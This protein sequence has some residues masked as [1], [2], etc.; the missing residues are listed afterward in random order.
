MNKIKKHIIPAILLIFIPFFFSCTNNN[1]SNVQSRLKNKQIVWSI[2]D[3]PHFLDPGLCGYMDGTDVINNMFEGLFRVTKKDNI[4]FGVVKSYSCSEDKK[5][6][7]F[8]FKDDVYWSDGKKVSPKDFEFSW[9]RVL[10]PDFQSPRKNLFLSLKNADNI[11]N[12]S[13]DISSLGVKALNDHQ[14]KIDLEHPVDHLF[15]LLSLTPFMPIR[16][17][18]VDSE[19]LFIKDTKT[20]ISN[21]P[22]FLERVSDNYLILKKNIFY[23]NA[24][25][26]NVGS[27]LV[28]FINDS[29]TAYIGYKSKNIDIIDNVPLN[30]LQ[31]LYK[32]DEFISIPYYGMYFYSFNLNLNCLKNKKTRQAISAAIDRD[33]IIKKIRKSSEKPANEYIHPDFMKNITGSSVIKNS[34][35]LKKAKKLFLESGFDNNNKFPELEILFNS[36]SENKIIAEVVQEMLKNN[37]NIDVKLH[38]NEWSIFNNKRKKLEY[39]G[40]VKN[41]YIVESFD[42]ISFLE[43][44]RPGGISYCG[45]NNEKYNLILNNILNINSADDKNKEILKAAQILDDEMPIIPLFYYSSSSLAQPYIKNY[46]INYIGYKFLGF[47]KI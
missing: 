47:I 41:S 46:Y 8:E 23:N 19:N 26:S 18:M 28:K 10:N 35:D 45:Y 4:T 14:L 6:Y 36:E 30:E 40:L 27:V 11:I 12:H 42:P 16:E 34:F 1:D 32:S 39:N 38:G 17:D 2:P 24:D 5:T 31:K 37:L 25:K 21:G 33:A 13:Y 7:I 9:K 20:F 15:K 29:N 43:I 3:K 22:F 44:F